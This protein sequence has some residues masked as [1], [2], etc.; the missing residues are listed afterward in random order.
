MHDTRT[1]YQ[2]LTIIHNT[3]IGN[4]LKQNNDL[5]TSSQLNYHCIYACYS[6]ISILI[7]SC[8]TLQKFDFQCMF[9]FVKYFCFLFSIF[10]NDPKNT[11][12]GQSK[13]RILRYLLKSVDKINTIDLFSMCL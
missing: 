10:V 13:C 1:L 11:I 4:K 8:C 3:S 2:T 9:V 12:F 6:F 5:H 7:Q